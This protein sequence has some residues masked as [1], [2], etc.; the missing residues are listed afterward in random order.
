M[1]EK[2]RPESKSAAEPAIAQADSAKPPMERFKAVT[3]GMLKVTP[4]E[5]AERQR[6]RH[7]LQDHTD[8]DNEN[9]EQYQHHVHQGRD[10]DI[11]H[12]RPLFLSASYV[13]RHI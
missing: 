12:R 1:A 7:L 4:K 10:V 9:D 8:G 2:S 13:Q 11:R 5:L 6:Q 3:R